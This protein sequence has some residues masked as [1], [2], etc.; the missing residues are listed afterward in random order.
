MKCRTLYSP[1]RKGKSCGHV[2]K[3]RKKSC[4]RALML[5]T[6]R[7]HWSGR[8]SSTLGGSL[9][10]HFCQFPSVFLL[11]CV[12]KSR[13]RL[14]TRSTVIIPTR[15]LFCLSSYFTSNSIIYV[16]SSSLFKDLLS[17]LQSAECRPNVFIYLFP[18]IF[19]ISWKNEKEKENV[20]CWQC[21]TR[22]HKLPVSQ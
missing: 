20:S 6:F 1:Y 9:F 2:L 21:P 8:N 18:P 3:R 17:V 22:K 16:T 19:S 5:W 11:F 10:H 13:Q 15:F 14:A 4:K 7:M 12:L